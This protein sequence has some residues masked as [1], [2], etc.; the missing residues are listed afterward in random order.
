MLRVHALYNKLYTPSA[1]TPP[2]R[3]CLSLLGRLAGSERERL[4][5]QAEIAAP[6]DSAERREEMEVAMQQV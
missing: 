6:E 1:P 3:L 2:Q 4:L 5:K